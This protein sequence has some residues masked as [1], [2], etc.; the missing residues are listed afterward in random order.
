MPTL[1]ATIGGATANSYCTAAVSVDALALLV[2]ADR[3]AAWIAL[4]EPSKEV[5]LMR[6]TKLLDQNFDWAGYRNT[7][8]QALAW[9]RYLAYD[10][11]QIIVGEDRI[12]SKVVDATCLLA[13]SISEGSTA[14]DFAASP[15]KQL[16]VGTIR[17][18]FNDAEGAR[19]TATIPP[20]VIECLPPI[21]EYNGASGGARSVSLVRG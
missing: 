2:S 18:D 8:A 7:I 16:R 4:D 20:E 11:D 15:L 17:M 9:P 21:G 3:L 10:V 19:V 1:D 5:F 14:D 13:I 6:A 12:P